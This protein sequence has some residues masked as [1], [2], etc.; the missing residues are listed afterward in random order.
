[1]FSAGYCGN[2]SEN[3]QSAR[4]AAGPPR[5]EHRNENEGQPHLGLGAGIEKEK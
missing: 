2:H 5:E 1:M 4:A 3:G